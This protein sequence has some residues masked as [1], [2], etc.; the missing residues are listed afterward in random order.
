MEIAQDTYYV[1]L[2]R[3]HTNFLLLKCLCL[4]ILKAFLLMCVVGSGLTRFIMDI[5]SKEDLCSYIAHLCSKMRKF[6][7][8]LR[9]Q[10]SKNRLDNS[11]ILLSEHSLQF[12]DLIV[13]SSYWNMPKQSKQSYSVMFKSLKKTISEKLRNCSQF[14][15]ATVNLDPCAGTP[16]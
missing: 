2:Q 12:K 9:W 10:S 3:I 6:V 5:L 4:Q 1:M 8:S 15:C 16:D 7:I 14:G 13:Y 11:K